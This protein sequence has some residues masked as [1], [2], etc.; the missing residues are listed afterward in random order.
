MILKYTQI[1]ILKNIM[2]IIKLLVKN[3]GNYTKYHYI[4]NILT[5]KM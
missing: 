1:V 3:T 5:F 4:K 2:T